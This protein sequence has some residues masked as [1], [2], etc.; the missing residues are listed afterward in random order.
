MTRRG[1][2][3]VHP[4][5]VVRMSHMATAN[6]RETG[7]HSLAMALA[8][9]MLRKETTGCHGQLAVFAITTPQAA[10]VPFSRKLSLRLKLHTN[11]YTYEW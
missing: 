10:L 2:H 5:P 3:H 4:H 11:R 8:A 6:S 9:N 7:K 1:V